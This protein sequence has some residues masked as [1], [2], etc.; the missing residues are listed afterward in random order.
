MPRFSVAENIMLERLPQRG[1]LLDIRATEAAARRYLDAIGLAID[2]RTEVRHLS[3]AQM[4]MVEIAKAV[5][6]ETRVLLLD[7]PT[8]SISPHRG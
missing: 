3:V 8:A 4:Q 7:E 5:R 1:G 2:P 6:Q